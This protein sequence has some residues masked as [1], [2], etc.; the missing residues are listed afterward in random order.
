MVPNPSN[1]QAFSW[2]NSA[3]YLSHTYK[4]S[5][6]SHMDQCC[7][8]ILGASSS[9]RETFILSLTHMLTLHLTVIRSKPHQVVK[10]HWKTQ[11]PLGEGGEC[12][13]VIPTKKENFAWLAS[14]IGGSIESISQ[15]SH[16]IP[17]ILA[18]WIFWTAFPMC[19]VVGVISG[20]TWFKH[21]K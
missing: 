11:L 7:F 15:D 5:S 14:K 10:R 8:Q 13:P 1:S 20:T 9:E 3:L 6:T 19:D 17:V 18:Y 16:S 12:L 21:N 2:L 4:P